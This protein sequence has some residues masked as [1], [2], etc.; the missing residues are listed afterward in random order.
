[1]SICT[2]NLNINWKC[3]C[4]SMNMFMFETNIEYYLSIEKFHLEM[5]MDMY[6]NL[7]Y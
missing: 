6:F 7:E 2:G 3:V 1:M 4:C 5:Y